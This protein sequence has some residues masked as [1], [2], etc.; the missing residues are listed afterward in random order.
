MM[1]AYTRNFLQVS[2]FCTLALFSTGC[3]DELKDAL[4]DASGENSLTFTGDASGFTIKMTV[5]DVGTSSDYYHVRYLL[6]SGSS[7]R[8]KHGANYEGTVETTCSSV[9][10]SGNDTVY[11]CT[12]TYNTDSPVGDPSPE[13]EQISL[14]PGSYQVVLDEKSTGNDNETEVATLSVN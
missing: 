1:I 10:Y 6:K 12:T 14:A 7:E 13:T 8:I 9:G 4:D 5:E 11:N 3:I 2:M